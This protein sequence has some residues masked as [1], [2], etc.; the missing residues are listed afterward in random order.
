MSKIKN[1]EGLTFRDK[2]DLVIKTGLQKLP[3]VG[4][5]FGL[6]YEAKKEKRIRRLESSLY[7][8]THRIDNLQEN[9]IREIQEN[10]QSLDEN[11][12]EAIVFIID[13]W[14]EKIEAEIIDKKIE[15]LKQYFLNTLK[16]PAKENNFDER[17]FFLD[18]LAAMSLLECELLTKLYDHERNQF[19][20]ISDL[21][22]G[23]IDQYAI[24]GAINRMKSYGFL[25]SIRPT[26]FGN[27]EYE[28]REE[29]ELSPFGLKFCEFCIKS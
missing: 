4:S 3:Y 17:R 16:K 29:I 18:K 25:R 2:R 11:D 20:P 1:D 15:Y 13:E 8:L 22:M 5:I 28:L 19:V 24:I 23:G 26:V 12:R 10:L 6:Y 7:D 21:M 14:F 27:A 9:E